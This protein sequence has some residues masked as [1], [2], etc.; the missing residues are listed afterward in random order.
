MDEWTML[1]EAVRDGRWRGAAETARALTEAWD[2]AKSMV[3]GFAD[4]DGKA[5]LRKFDATLSTLVSHLER[6]P[7]DGAAVLAAAAKLRAMLPPQELH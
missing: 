4:E 2:S 6:R 5:Y 3:S 1:E 7:V